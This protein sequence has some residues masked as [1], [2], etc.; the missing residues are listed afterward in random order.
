MSWLNYHHLLYFWMAAREGSI[1][2]ACRQLHL[3]QPTVSGQI[4]VLER[5]LKLRL[6]ERAGR[7]IR[8]TD[9]GQMVY[10]YA[11]EI[12]SLGREREEARVGPPAGRPRS[13]TWGG[14]SISR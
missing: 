7:S 5:T 14:S 12:F 10:R 2:K 1:T 11:D 4:R 6:F 3:T 9:A 13:M 8:L